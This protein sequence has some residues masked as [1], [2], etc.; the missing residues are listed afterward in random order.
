MNVKWILIRRRV[1]IGRC[2]VQIVMWTSTKCFIVFTG[3]P[4]LLSVMLMIISKHLGSWYS[5]GLLWPFIWPAGHTTWLAMSTDS[6]NPPIHPP[7]PYMWHL[8]YCTNCRL[9]S[10]HLSKNQPVAIYVAIVLL[11]F[12][13]KSYVATI[14]HKKAIILWNFKSVFLENQESAYMESFLKSGH[15]YIQ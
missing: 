6:V 5:Q 9:C 3:V 12:W 13:C 14:Q 1:I 4:L 2:I 8:W 11:Y 15:I 7:T 10:K